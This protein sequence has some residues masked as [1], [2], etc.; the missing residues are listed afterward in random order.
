MSS[1]S[2]TSDETAT[3]L[4]SIKTQLGVNA[5]DLES[6]REALE[7]ETNR[8]STDETVLLTE[9]VQRLR[10]KASKLGR[11]LERL[12]R[13]NNDYYEVSVGVG[14]VVVVVHFDPSLRRL[15]TDV[16]CP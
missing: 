2:A 14:H 7:L 8:D 6:A 3:S 11:I 15:A 1:S 16:G 9:S 10:A 5:Q 13:K 4:R 12:E